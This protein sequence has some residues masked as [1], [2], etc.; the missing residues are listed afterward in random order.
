M[1]ATEFQASERARLFGVV[2]KLN[3]KLGRAA[4]RRA[5]RGDAR[6]P[7]ICAAAD[8]LGITREHAYRVLTGER[9]SRTLIRKLAKHGLT[10][11]RGG[12]R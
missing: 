3:W 7:G 12:R 5:I 9:Q 1:S 6:F 11:N 2:R 4:G 10:P 8:A